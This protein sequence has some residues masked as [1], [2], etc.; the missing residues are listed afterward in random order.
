MFDYIASQITKP[1]L[2]FTCVLRIAIAEGI[3]HKI[4]NPA[5]ALGLDGCGAVG[6][7]F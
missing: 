2:G 5:V 3:N 7:G 1:N 6:K 4:G